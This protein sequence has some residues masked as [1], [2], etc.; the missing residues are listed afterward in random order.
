MKIS[1][2]SPV[3]RVLSRFRRNRIGMIAL[4]AILILFVV[5][6]VFAFLSTAHVPFPTDPNATNL[7]RK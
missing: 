4:A 5:V 3:R 6:A 1:E 7:E 2:Q